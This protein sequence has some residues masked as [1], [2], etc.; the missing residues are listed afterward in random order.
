MLKWNLTAPPNMPTNR[1]SEEIK[2][3]MLLV[4]DLS[5]KLPSYGAMGIR[6][7]CEKYLRDEDKLKS[8]MFFL[9]SR[10]QDGM[11]GD[12]CYDHATQI[13]DILLFDPLLPPQNDN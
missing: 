3:L 12:E 11:T 7:I 4:P 10:S 13:Q 5:D 2:R 9:L 8:L 1:T 6:A